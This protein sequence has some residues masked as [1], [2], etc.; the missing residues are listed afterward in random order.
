MSNTNNTEGAVSAIIEDVAPGDWTEK[1]YK[2]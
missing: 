2:K 1:V